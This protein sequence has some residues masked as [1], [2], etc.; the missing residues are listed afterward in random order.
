MDECELAGATSQGKESDW[1]SCSLPPRRVT[2]RG[3]PARLGRHSQE[4]ELPI[5]GRPR[6]LKAASVV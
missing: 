3:V 4:R 2:L 6:D 5:E 1:E